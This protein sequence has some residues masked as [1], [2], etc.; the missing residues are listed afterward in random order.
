MLGVGAYQ[1][2]AQRHRDALKA[3]LGDT[4]QQSPEVELIQRDSG[5]VDGD[6]GAEQRGIEYEGQLCLQQNGDGFNGRDHGDEYD[7]PPAGA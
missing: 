2:V 6:R 4:A 5:H 3:A 1:A 7:G